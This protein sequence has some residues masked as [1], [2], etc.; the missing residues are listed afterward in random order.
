MSVTGQ[1]LGLVREWGN[2]FDGWDP[3]MDA[4]LQKLDTVVQLNFL[5]A[6]T[7]AQPGSPTA[8]DVYLVPVSATG[9]SWSGKDKKVALWTGAA[10]TYYTPKHGWLGWV[11]D[12]N[13]LLVF[14]ATDWVEF[15]QGSSAVTLS[16]ADVAVTT[17]SLAAAAEGS[18]TAALGKG[19]VV[20]KVAADRA[21]RVR[22]YV[23]AAARS[24]DT[25]RVVGVEPAAGAGLILEMVFA[26]AGSVILSPAAIGA[27]LEASP[28][29]DVPYLISNL[30]GSTS[31]VTV[32][33]TRVLSETS[34]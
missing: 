16:R 9:A 14:H 29:D 32:T 7:I 5:S 28:T 12:T 11:R 18:G 13:K 10:W 20:L 24:A 6:T 4:N 26:A 17:T 19:F 34:L 15:L 27:N 21:C 8:G 30:S 22:V 33:F 23:N 25:S 2:G 31:T 3:D 1:N